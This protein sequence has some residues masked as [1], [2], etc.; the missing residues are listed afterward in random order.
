M[1][2]HKPERVERV[3]KV[4]PLSVLKTTGTGNKGDSRVESDLPVF[5]TLLFALTKEHL[6]E[7]CWSWFVV[8][9]VQSTMAGVVV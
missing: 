2:L 8:S 7:N 1:A 6:K 4:I 5:V 3:P 9:G